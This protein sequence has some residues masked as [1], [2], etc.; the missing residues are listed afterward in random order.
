MRLLIATHNPGKI[1]EYRHLLAGLQYELVSLDDV[2]I[3]ND[4]AETGETY[5][6]NAR[7]KAHAY[8]QQSGLLTLADDSGLE[9]DALGGAPAAYSARFAG[10]GATDADRVRHL[11]A[12]LKG[13]PM[14]QRTARFRCVIA[15][16][17]PSG[18]EEVVEGVCE[19]QITKGPR[20]D[21]GFGYD[22]VFLVAGDT[23]TMAE[24]TSA[25]KNAI[26]HRAR[27]AARARSLL[28]MSSYSS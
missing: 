15:L 19:G 21:S 4:V 10:P 26:S 24:L 2:G 5:A 14:A 23:R 6:A 22:P 1:R 17:W 27:A 20:G 7:L 8:A 28:A 12:Q 3:T 16:V 13:V 9:V 25:E 11:L 18:R